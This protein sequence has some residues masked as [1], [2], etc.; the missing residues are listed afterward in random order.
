V[1][2]SAQSDLDFRIVNGGK[3]AERERF[4]LSIRFWRMLP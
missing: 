4:E 2:K 3:M 1:R